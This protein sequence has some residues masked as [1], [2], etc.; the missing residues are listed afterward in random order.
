MEKS[1]ISHFA[2]CRVVAQ[3]W[4]AMITNKGVLVPDD[5]NTKDLGQFLYVW[6]TVITTRYTMSIGCLPPVLFSKLFGRGQTNGFL[7]K[8]SSA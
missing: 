7:T 5:V 6:L 4:E 1:I 3:E 2:R 8:D